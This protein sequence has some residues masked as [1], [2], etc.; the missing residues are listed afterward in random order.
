MNQN[1]FSD[2]TN[3]TAEEQPT[4]PPVAQITCGDRRLYRFLE[5]ELAHLGVQAVEAKSDRPICLWIVDMDETEDNPAQRDELETADCP[6]L[7]FGRRPIRPW[8]NE[9][10]HICEWILLRRPFALPQLEDALR[11]LTQ[12][13]TTTATPLAPAPSGTIAAS[14]SLSADTLVTDIEAGTVLISGQ[15][16]PLS[17]AEWI[18]WKQLYTRRGD[19]VSRAE[20]AVRLDGEG[21]VNVHICHLREKLEK[22]LGRRLI[23]TV[24]GVGYRLFP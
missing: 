14:P 9:K 24:R 15:A 13:T 21:S 17:P 22:P 19:I 16:V 7:L 4:H 5:I 11:H 8:S 1:T 18:L 2:Q 23:E 6:V 3:R 20:L 12:G 10:S